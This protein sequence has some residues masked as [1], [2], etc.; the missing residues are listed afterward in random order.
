MKNLQDMFKKAEEDVQNRLD[1]LPV[2][3]SYKEI[4]KQI[5]NIDERVFEMLYDEDTENSSDY[6]LENVD[7]VAVHE[8]LA[9]F[10]N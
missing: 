3:G 4:L 7:L 5:L 9:Q 10:Q 1:G 2:F 6:E 8:R